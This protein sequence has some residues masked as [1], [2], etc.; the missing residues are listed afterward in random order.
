[1]TFFIIDFFYIIVTVF[2]FIELIYVH[3]FLNIVLQYYECQQS[4][5]KNLKNSLYIIEAKRK[6][7]G[8]YGFIL[9]IT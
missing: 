3:I 2:I 1:M 4:A 9:N 7:F 8:K 6:K 5:D